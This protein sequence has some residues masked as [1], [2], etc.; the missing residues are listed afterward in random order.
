ME[1]RSHGLLCGRRAGIEKLK[2]SQSND[3]QNTIE[4]GQV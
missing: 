3:L 2:L 1:S 4:S